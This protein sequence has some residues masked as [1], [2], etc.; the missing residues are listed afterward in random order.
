MTSEGS[1]FYSAEWVQDKT[2]RKSEPE[3]KNPK[4]GKTPKPKVEGKKPKGQVINE[5]DDDSKSE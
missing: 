3:D 4:P 1:S 5:S 2:K